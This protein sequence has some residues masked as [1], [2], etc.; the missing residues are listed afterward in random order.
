S[1]AAAHRTKTA[2]KNCEERGERRK[3]AA[4][5]ECGIARTGGENLFV[6]RIIGTA[7]DVC[8]CDRSAERETD[9]STGDGIGTAILYGGYSLFVG[10]HAEQSWNDFR[11]RAGAIIREMDARGCDA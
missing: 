8:D 2:R 9:Q 1:A 3:S 10:P 7:A 11:Q 6:E 5:N 4:G